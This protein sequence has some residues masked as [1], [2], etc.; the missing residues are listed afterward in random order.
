MSWFTP[1]RRVV[2]TLEERAAAMGVPVSSPEYVEARRCAACRRLGNPS[3]VEVILPD[4]PALH[5]WTDMLLCVNATACREHCV[6]TGTWK[7][8]GRT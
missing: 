3:G 1:E 5:M 2:P 8:Y 4:A 6:K 7:S